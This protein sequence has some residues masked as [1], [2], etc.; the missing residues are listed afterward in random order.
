MTAN[1]A[2]LQ[3]PEGYPSH[4]QFIST[5]ADCAVFR[6]FT[7][8]N[9]RNLL[10]LQTNVLDLEAQLY[11]HDKNDVEAIN[12]KSVDCGEREYAAKSY[13]HLKRGQQAVDQM[14]YELILRI[15]QSLKVYIMTTDPLNRRVM[16]C[17]N[18]YQKVQNLLVDLGKDYLESEDLAALAES[19]TNS[20]NLTEGIRSLFGSTLRVRAQHISDSGHEFGYVPHKRVERIVNIVQVLLATLFLGGAIIGLFFVKSNKIR[21]ALIPP[22]VGMFALCMTFSST[23]SKREI[24]GA[25]AAYAAVLVVFES[26][27]LSV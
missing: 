24:Y 12:A 10:Y 13:L 9:V 8:L 16:Q 23:A 2:N 15:R 6:K 25:S 7:E 5:S 27:G 18:S 14:R 20:D 3:R 22:L 1:P 26:G 19:I 11:L 17:L 21:L 4:A